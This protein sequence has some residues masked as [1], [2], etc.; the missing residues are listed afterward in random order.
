MVRL[1]MAPMPTVYFLIP[2]ARIPEE[3]LKSVLDKPLAAKLETAFAGLG[4]AR[5]EQLSGGILSPFSRCA[6]HLWFWS[7]V[8]RAKTTPAHAGYVW[9][10]DHG[11]ALATE[12]WDVTPC[13]LE[14]GRTVSLADD[15]L[16][17]EEIDRCSPAIRAALE[18][19]GF[20]L[21]QW[22]ELWY[23]SRTKDWDAVVRPWECQAGF[24]FDET[25]AEGD[26]E[27]AF[28]LMRRL[29]EVIAESEV[30]R[31]RRAAGRPAPD[32]V[33]VSG[34]GRP[35]RFYPPTKIRAVLSDEP[36]LRSWAM[37]A[38]ILCQ[39]VGKTSG[40]EWPSDAPPGDVI[41]VVSDL[42]A[43]WLAGDWQAWARALPGTLEKI[44]VIRE[45]ALAR[46][47]ETAV[48]IACGDGTTA[49]LA[50]AKATL[51]SRLLSRFAKKTPADLS[52]LADSAPSETQ[53]GDA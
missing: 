49:T 52:W 16:S 43:P 14:A 30:A 11:P 25:A 23:A 19:E 21:Q 8:T 27:K 9:L 24:A 12:V 34:G 3:A 50:P 17:A 38:G 15:P 45:K 7:V 37:E 42:W 40:L 53:G 51:K 10:E 13:R 2:G 18:K 46:K 22:D 41:A 44:A 48:F 26:R 39:Y 36:V 47:D 6:H 33:W 35:V 28:S 31:E 32:F 5:I 4:E 29:G 20:V 1:K